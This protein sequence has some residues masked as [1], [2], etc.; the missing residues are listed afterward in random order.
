M[1]G[2]A[3]SPAATRGSAAL[4]WTHDAATFTL[5]VATAPGR[6]PAREWVST[7]TFDAAGVAPIRLAERERG[8][9]KRALNID[10]DGGRVRFSGATQALPLAPGTQDRW[11]WIAQLAAIAEAASASAGRASP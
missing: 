3:R 7:G 6:Q 9:D 2:D 11:S 8:R 1:Q 10:R 5:R 4:D